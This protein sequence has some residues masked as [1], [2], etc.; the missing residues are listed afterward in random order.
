MNASSLYVT[1]LRLVFQND[2][3][4]VHRLFPYLRQLLS[5]SVCGNLLR[6]PFSPLNSPCQH[7][8]CKTCVGGRKILKPSCAWC[9]DRPDTVQ[10][11]QLRLLLQCYKSLCE[12]IKLTPIYEGMQSQV[13]INSQSNSSAADHSGVGNRNRLADI[14]DEGIRFKD[15]FKSAAGLS[16]A[17]YS[18][19][20]CLYQSVVTE[21]P[22]AV[23]PPPPP[24]PPS[25]P[26]I[27]HQQQIHP[28]QQYIINSGGQIVLQKSMHSSSSSSS[29]NLLL[30]PP[31]QQPLQNQHLQ[32]I[33]NPGGGGLIATLSNQRSL[34]NSN[35]GS[36]SNSPIQPQ[37]SGGVKQMHLPSSSINNSVT[38][39]NNR[40]IQTTVAANGTV[41]VTKSQFVPPMPIIKTVSNGSAL[42]SVMYAGS[43]NK[44][45]IKRKTDSQSASSAAHAHHNQQQLLSEGH[46][47]PVEMGKTSSHPSS[48][49]SSAA[50]SSSPTT[51]NNSSLLL[52]GSSGSMTS[53]NYVVQDGGGGDPGAGLGFK[54][55]PMIVKSKTLAKRKGCRCGNAT[56]TPGK[57]TCCG[58]RCPCY[59]ESKSCIDCKCRGCRNPHRP[60]GFKVRPHIPELENLDFHLHAVEQQSQQ[61]QPLMKTILNTLSIVGNQQQQQQHAVASSS[62]SSSSPA[63]S[64]S[65]VKVSN[66]AATSSSSNNVDDGTRM[67][68]RLNGII[69]GTRTTEGLCDLGS[70]LNL[71]SFQS[72]GGGNVSQGKIQGE[73]CGQSCTNLVRI[74]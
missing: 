62:N 47:D 21:P 66:M 14:I 24:P 29:S 73:F 37:T 74:Y 31:Q 61:Q 11:V 25:Q 72:G 63:S 39:N 64:S 27:V 51:T 48:S 13:Q 2:A 23:T 46:K 57:L 33:Q 8:E 68:S 15:E 10:N 20:P 53:S 5:C 50:V 40:I 65:L 4:N 60:N 59:V 52:Q 36:S 54:K 69:G 38:T 12:Y 67:D 32:K 71:H 35:S 6:E 18:M 49:S 56:L 45:T 7:H 43:G 41:Y 42:Y 30:Q 34:I 55:P 9:R 28:Q 3:P 26:T 44:I 16:K 22:A 17:T 70:N 1:V 19:L 58:Q